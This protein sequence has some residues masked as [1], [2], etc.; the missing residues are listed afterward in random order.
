MIKSIDHVAVMVKDLEVSA[1]FYQENF[2][3]QQVLEREIPNSYVKKIAFFRLAGGESELELMHVPEAK[4][5]EGI[6]ISFKTD[7]FMADYNR[8]KEAG[9]PVVVE[10]LE[11]PIRY[12]EGTGHRAMFRGPDHE[13]LEIYG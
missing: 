6:H 4:P 8:L 2:G 9:L 10:P 11:V 5:V 12:G 1:K 13:L 3:F 7:N